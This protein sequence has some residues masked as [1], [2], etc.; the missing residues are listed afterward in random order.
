MSTI[1]AI[2]IFSNM[3]PL[4]KPSFSSRLLGTEFKTNVGFL[5]SVTNLNLSVTG[6]CKLTSL[7]WAHG[8]LTCPCSWLSIVWQ[9]I[10]FVECVNIQI[11]DLF[12]KINTN[13]WIYE[14]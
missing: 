10:V 3:G 13:T 5:E 2:F 9:S 1:V 7:Q 4:T 6:T 12:N 14:F 8:S 11:R